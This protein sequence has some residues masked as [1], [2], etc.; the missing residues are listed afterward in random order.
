[1]DFKLSEPKELLRET[2]REFAEKEITPHMGMMEETGE[3]P[4]PLLRKMGDM[5]ILG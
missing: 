1:M 5:G 3:F 4:L 2:I